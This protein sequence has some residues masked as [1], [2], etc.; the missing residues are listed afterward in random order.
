VAKGRMNLR[1]ENT[2][3]TAEKLVKVDGSQIHVG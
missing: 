1:G 3:L 2:L